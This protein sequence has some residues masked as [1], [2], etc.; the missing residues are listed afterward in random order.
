[1][2]IAFTLLQSHALRQR[3][4]ALSDQAPDLTLYRREKP[5]Y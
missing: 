3:L 5:E 4:L 2:A 1:M